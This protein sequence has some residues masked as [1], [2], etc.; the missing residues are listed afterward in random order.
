[1]DLVVGPSNISRVEMGSCVCLSFCRSVP[2][3][4]GS[5]FT[6]AFVLLSTGGDSG[7][8]GCLAMLVA[9]ATCFGDDK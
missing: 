3:T 4:E 8:V 1:M 7:G 5:G 6:L 9:L 2:S